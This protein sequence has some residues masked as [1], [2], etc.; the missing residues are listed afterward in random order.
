MA[1]R[2]SGLDRGFLTYDDELPDARRIG[3]DTVVRALEWLG[4][5]GPDPFFLFVHLFDAHGPYSSPLEFQQLFRS[6]SPGSRLG[7]IPDYQQMRDEQEQLVN[8]VNPYIDLYDSAIRFTDTLIAALL[9]AVDL[10]T[11]VVVVAADHGE[12]LN[13]RYWSVDHGGHVFD[14][15]TRVPLLIHAPGLEQRRVSALVETVDL[16]PTLLHL[17]GIDLPADTAVAGRS[18]IPLLTGDKNEWRRIVFS[19]AKAI[20]VRYGDRGYDLNPARKIYSARSKYWKLISYPGMDQDYWE[21]Y[22]LEAD[23]MEETDVAKQHPEVVDELRF[24]MANWL[25]TAR[26]TQFQPVELSDDE[27]QKLLALGY[28][29]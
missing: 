15:Q 8:T 27:R 10:D 11:T 28:L 29:E 20:S 17:L 1:G 22:D 9:D 23:P 5:V 24:A 12:S 6:D 4:E 21:L 14:E 7:V 18:L 19:S 2:T 13:E 3:A 16:M 26:K 25:R